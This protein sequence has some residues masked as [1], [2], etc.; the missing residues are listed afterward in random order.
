MMH[1]HRSVSVLGH[2]E[3]IAKIID[4]IRC[5]SDG[6]LISLRVVVG[7]K[8]DVSRFDLCAYGQSSNV[9]ENI[10]ALDRHLE[11]S[12]RGECWNPNL[13]GVRGK[14]LH[15]YK[16]LALLTLRT[17]QFNKISDSLKRTDGAAVVDIV[18]DVIREFVEVQIVD[19]SV[20]ISSRYGV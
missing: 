3:R 8:F 14:R 16:R 19:Q 18:A 13:A 6:R 12:F 1:L 7:P 15:R 2:R 10:H 4:A 9:A 20:L 17:G 11:S 5:A